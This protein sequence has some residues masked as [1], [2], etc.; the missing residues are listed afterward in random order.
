V[1]TLPQVDARIH[2]GAELLRGL[3]A[4]GEYLGA[5]ARSESHERFD[6]ETTGCIRFDPTRE[7]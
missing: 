1:I 3:D 5:D 4:L 6:Q 2:Q 7:G